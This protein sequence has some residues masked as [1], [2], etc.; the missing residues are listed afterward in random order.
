MFSFPVVGNSTA[1]DAEGTSGS[2]R[3]RKPSA[4]VL[5]LQE[6]K[7]RKP[8]ARIKPLSRPLKSKYK[9]GEDDMNGYDYEDDDTDE[10]L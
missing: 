2:K 7:V 4:K 9:L 1:D 5:E 8:S 3:K 6:E 10:Y